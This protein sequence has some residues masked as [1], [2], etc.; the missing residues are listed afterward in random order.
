MALS[1]TDHELERE[2]QPVAYGTF[3]GY[4]SDSRVQ[5]DLP[6]LQT[7][8]DFTKL[9][10][11]LPVSTRVNKSDSDVGFLSHENTT[12]DLTFPATTSGDQAQNDGRE[13]RSLSSYKPSHA[14]HA[15][16]SRS[17]DTDKFLAECELQFS[18]LFA[19]IDRS[20][21]AIER[22]LEVG[23]CDRLLVSNDHYASLS[24]SFSVGGPTKRELSKKDLRENVAFCDT[25]L[26]HV[27]RLKDCLMLNLQQLYG[28]LECYSTTFPDDRNAIVDF[29]ISQ[30]Q[31]INDLTSDLEQ[32]KGNV[33]EHKSYAEARLTVVSWKDLMRPERKQLTLFA[34]THFIIFLLS[35]TVLCW[36]GGGD[37][38]YVGLFYLFRGPMFIIL[39]LYLY[40]LNLVGWATAKVRYIDI[41]NF[42]S[43]EETPTPY[44][45]FNIAG[46]LSLTFAMFVSALLL[47]EHLETTET[48]ERIL[49][50]TLWII[51]ILFL[52]N[53]FKWF[54]QKGRWK[55][56]K[57]FWSFLL[58]PFYQVRFGD[59]WLL[60]NLNSTIVIFLDFEFLICFCTYVWPLDKEEDGRVCNDNGYAVRPI[61]SCLPAFL[62]LMQCLRCFHDTKNYVYL[63]D[64][65]KASTTFPVVILFVLFSEDHPRL[66]EHFKLESSEGY[67]FIAWLVSS[68]IHAVFNFIWDI[69]MDWGLL[70]YRNLLREKL[71]YRW[72]ILYYLAILEN[73]ILRFAWCLKLSLG[74]HLSARY[75]LF[76]TL[77]ASLEIL[78][79]FVW[80]FFRVEY[81]HVKLIALSTCEED[82]DEDRE[83]LL[84]EH[85]IN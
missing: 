14:S 42:S 58:A 30:R 46:V 66:T 1:S 4:D 71:I 11:F 64:A 6:L 50:L 26:E 32:C 5:A 22:R 63:I 23:K 34:F 47:V 29:E 12:V 82:K 10:K 9:R 39:C 24:Q 81:E 85:S 59:Y 8:V 62:R 13:N 74:L 53:P 55:V 57:V 72:R 28:I 78:R 73:L 27:R 44:V 52:L 43:A 33:T 61:I 60:N 40:S 7:G 21:E 37:D 17:A 84:P 48:P 51:T 25:A 68:V 19:F 41:F 76:Y 56:V 20:I 67:I 18:R 35:V 2:L 31:T 15:S 16:V 70:H 75:N 77:L 45:I 69:Y 38:R 65:V 49:P 36:F 83:M 54:I 80:N 79:R 3:F